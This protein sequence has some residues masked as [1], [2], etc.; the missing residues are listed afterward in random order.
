MSPPA[1]QP[2]G[3][4]H[5]LLSTVQAHVPFGPGRGLFSFSPELPVMGSKV[6]STEPSLAGPTEEAHRYALFVPRE[7]IFI[8]VWGFGDPYFLLCI[9]AV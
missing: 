5:I 1:V 7:G 4:I 2:A 8:R 9:L 3:I 6:H